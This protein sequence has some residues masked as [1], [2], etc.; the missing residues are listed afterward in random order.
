MASL[1]AVGLAALLALAPARDLLAPE[2]VRE[3]IA[4]GRG[5]SEADLKQYDLK[6]TAAWEANFDTA[7]LRIAQLAAAMRRSD[8]ELGAADVPEKFA[9][10]E[11]HVYVHVLA[12]EAGSNLP[13]IDYMT[14]NKP[15]AGGRREPVLPRS[16]ERFVRQVP[17][18]GV[19]GPARLARSVR[20]TF[21]R[22]GLVS[23]VEL[24][25]VFSGG[26]TQAVVIDG[27]TL[28]R[29]R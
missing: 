12:S 8:K 11:V 28:A 14:L 22:S 16:F 15:A 2:R 18:P 4:W 10:D 27:E 17:R 13:D 6:T 21:P 26:T 20:A 24:R 19:V 5:A 1:P 9:V 29:V 7:F 23:G 3:A 25:L